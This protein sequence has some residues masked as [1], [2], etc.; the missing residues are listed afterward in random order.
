[1]ISEWQ[2]WECNLNIKSGSGMVPRIETL[3]NNWSK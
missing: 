1:M 2:E 3:C